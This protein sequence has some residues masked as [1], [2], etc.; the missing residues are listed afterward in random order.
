MGAALLNA[1]RETHEV[2][3][4]THAE[5]DIGDFDEVEQLMM[6]QECDLIINCAAVTNVD[7]CEEQRD[8]AFR[9]NAGAPE[10]LAQIAEDKGA[11]FIHFST[12]YVFDGHKRTPYLEE[13]EAAPIS[14]YG[15]S[16]REGEENGDRLAARELGHGRPL[17]VSR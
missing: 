11:R 6:H 1:Y 16:K 2:T 10:L 14:V 4:L 9:V 12:D 7:L 5:I 17:S 15:E 3:G 13:D 8:E